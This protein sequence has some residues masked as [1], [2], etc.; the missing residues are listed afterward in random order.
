MRD[1]TAEEELYKRYAVRVYTLCRRY[2]GDADDAKDLMIDT[3][4]QALEKID[5]YKY[6]GEGS[7]YAWISRIAINKALN[8]IKRH[9]WRMVPLDFREQDNIP[10]PT[11][12][13]VADI[14]KEKL[15]EWIA[16]LSELRRTVFNL[17]CIDGYSHQEI[18]K[19]LGISERGSTSTLAK[20]RRQ[21][22]EKIKQY[23]EDQDK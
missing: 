8:Q 2:L 23:L 16:G 20:A 4:I 3:L 14:P 11:E 22:K 12:E 19:M 18:G 21:L 7:L 13:E 5:N 10:E 15:L 6:R 1:R 9:R 17:Y